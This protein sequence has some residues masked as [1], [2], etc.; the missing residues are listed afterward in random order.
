MLQG[1]RPMDQ[2]TVHNLLSCLPFCWL[3]GYPPIHFV[4]GNAG[5]QKSV[6]SFSQVPLSLCQMPTFFHVGDTAGVTPAPSCKRMLLG[7]G[8]V[9]THLFIA[10]RAGWG[11]LEQSS[12][13]GSYQQSNAPFIQVL[14]I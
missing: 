13:L 10:L 2:Q 7:L 12:S 11:H 9:L 3:R 1:A 4:I 8:T 6:V 5:A 14:N